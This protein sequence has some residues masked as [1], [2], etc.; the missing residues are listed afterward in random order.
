MAKAPQEREQA[1]QQYLQGFDEADIDAM[2]AVL[3]AAETDADL[4]DM[5]TDLHEE[6]DMKTLLPFLPKRKRKNDESRRAGWQVAVATMVVAFFGLAAALFVSPELQ[7]TLLGDIFGPQPVNCAVTSIPEA[8][9]QTLVDIYSATNG[10]NWY[11]NTGWLVGDPCDWYRV[12]CAGGHVRWLNLSNLGLRGSL[13][14]LSQLTGLRTLDLSGFDSSGANSNSPILPSLPTSLH[15]LIARETSF[16]AGL[17]QLDSLSELEHLDLSMSDFSGSVSS[18]ARL[19]DLEVLF[20]NGNRFT[21]QLPNFTIMPALR[22]VNVSHNTFSGEVPAIANLENLI[23]FD[24]SSNHLTGAIPHYD[25][26]QIINAKFHGNNFNDHGFDP[27]PAS[28][29]ASADDVESMLTILDIYMDLMADGRYQTAYVLY[30][31]TQRNE[32]VTA[33]F[34]R[35]QLSGNPELYTGFGFIM[36]E[37]SE[38][39]PELDVLDA[40]GGVRTQLSGTFSYTDGTERDFTAIFFQERGTDSWRLVD[41]YIR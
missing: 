30:S 26:T 5:L 10:E 25:Q 19:N 31:T 14:D 29:M 23:T 9:C 24:V 21:G 41:V 15:T 20:L 8:E 35:R 27:E 39:T 1:V 18:L 37:A 17:E 7:D 28:E 22:Q 16:S 40:F 3:E 36:N 13:P 34:L 32:R 4:T 2:L 33:L 12:N 11:R 38:F 6:P